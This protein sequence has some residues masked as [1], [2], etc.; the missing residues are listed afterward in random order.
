MDIAAIQEL[1]G[2]FGTF[3]SNFPKFFDK[4]VSGL[5]TAVAFSSRVAGAT[6]TPA[7]AQ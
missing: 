5:D 2:Q 6:P 1:L 3:V 4:L 7:P